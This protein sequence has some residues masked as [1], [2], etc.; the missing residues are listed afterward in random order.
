MSRNHSSDSAIWFLAGAAVGATVALLFAP[1]SGERTRK[2]IGRKAEE[3]RDAIYDSGRDLYEKGK[4][5]A[6]EAANLF[7]RGRKIVEG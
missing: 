1:Q 3:G 6:D 4:E 7:E 2:L 5:I